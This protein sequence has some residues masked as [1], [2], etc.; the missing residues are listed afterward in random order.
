MNKI[1]RVLLPALALAVSAIGL[2]VQA[3][4]TVLRTQTA[5]PKH[6]DL[7]KVFLKHF[8][9]KLNAAGKGIVRIDY[10][11]G[12]EVTPAN[13]AADALKRGVFDLL[14]T[15][16]AYHTGIVPQ[17]MTLMPTNQTPSQYRAAGVMKILEPHWN[18]NLNAKVLAIG[19]TGGQ[20]HLYTV[21]KPVIKNGALD[22]TGFKI[23]A[24]GA[25]RPLIKALNATPVQISAGEVYTGLQRGV[26]DGFGWPTVGLHALGLDKV[27]K[28]RIDPPFYHLANVLLVNQDT[29]KKVPK[30]AQA[31]VEKVALEYEHASIDA[32]LAAAKVGSENVQ[33]TGVQVFKLEGDTAKKYLKAAYD[34][35]WN[36]AGEKVPAA[37][38]KALRAILYK[39]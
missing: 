2:P 8:V 20:F 26:V 11:G 17:G 29:W 16:A 34:A 14:H 4:E 15:P 28:Y 27:T 38:L 25:Y 9:E 19:E 6:H 39:E 35:M 10:I 37:E 3:A 30:E 1:T 7:S 33:K 18:K 23:R 31:I 36:R 12:P 21:K 22:L 5:L 32:M 24:T 13:K